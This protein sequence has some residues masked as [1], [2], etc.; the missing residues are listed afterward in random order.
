M[1]LEATEENYQKL[2]E[3][4]M[5]KPVEEKKIPPEQMKDFAKVIAGILPP[6]Q[7]NLVRKLF[8]ID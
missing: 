6:A 1:S 8:K 2:V 3:A 4:G 5:L 7:G